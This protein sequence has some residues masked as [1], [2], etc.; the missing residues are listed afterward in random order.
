M[1]IQLIF[2]IMMFLATHVKA[3]NK[4]ISLKLDNPIPVLNLGTFH[5]GYSP[6]AN[7]IEFDEHDKGNIAQVHQI[8]QAIAAFKPTVI[9]VEVEPSENEK[10][11]QAYQDYLMS[12]DMEFT[13]TSEVQL[14]AFEVG[15]L[16]NST[17]IYGIDYQQGYNYS[18]AYQLENSVDSESYFQYMK[19]LEKLEEE[20]VAEEMTVLE[21]LQMT[22]DPRYLDILLNINAD[23]LTHISSP[24]NYEGADEATKM[25]HRNLV[26]YSHLNQIRLDKGDRVFILMGGTHTAFFNMWLKRSPKY[27]LEDV[28][29]YLNAVQLDD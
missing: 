21:H 9:L 10:L 6:D 1:K 8:A 2:A 11:Q 26:M 28:T 13:N 19:L 14:L 27:E 20:Y 12:P 3:Q 29:E 17:R 23:M 16:A 25:Y 18:L 5:M 7:T 22:N 15:R 4:D 24:G